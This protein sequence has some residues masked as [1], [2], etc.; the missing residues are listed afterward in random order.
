MSLVDHL[1]GLC[2]KD[3]LVTAPV[4]TAEEQVNA[5]GKNDP[6]IGLRGAAI[7]PVGRAECR[8]AP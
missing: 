6:N 7:A 1:N 4:V 8:H 3:L 2:T 5:A